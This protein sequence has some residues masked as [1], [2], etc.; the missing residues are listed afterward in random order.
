MGRVRVP[1][2]WED[3]PN[4]L[5]GAGHLDVSQLVALPEAPDVRP[6]FVSGHGELDGIRPT[7]D[8]RDMMAQRILRH[9]DGSDAARAWVESK[10]GTA[11]KNW[12][13]GVRAGR[14]KR[15]T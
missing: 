13:R 2:P 8:S 3:L 10:C 7:R 14:I 11:A 9:T 5:D 12:D 1:F 15:H 4:P 6:G